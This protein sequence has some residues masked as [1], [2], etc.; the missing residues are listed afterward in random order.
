MYSAAPQEDRIQTM[1]VNSKPQVKSNKRPQEK[2]LEDVDYGKPQ[3][4]TRSRVS[5][6]ETWIL[7]LAL[8]D[9][10]AKQ[11]S[12]LVYVRLQPQGKG[13]TRDCNPRL[14]LTS[15]PRTEFSEHAGYGKPQ[16]KSN[17]EAHGE[18]V[19]NMLI[20]ANH[21]SVEQEDPEKEPFVKL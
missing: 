4:E 9:I 8:V 6:L 7:Q 11:D 17:K 10:L 14:N 21:R 5:M 3:A 19:R 1:L 13:V 16:V 15:R 2:K 20:T 12:D 18:R